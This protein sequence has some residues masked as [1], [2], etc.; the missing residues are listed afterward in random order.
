MTSKKY[1]VEHC[2]RHFVVISSH[3][4]SSHEF[5]TEVAR[6]CD[7]EFTWIS[8]MDACKSFKH[9]QFPY[10]FSTLILEI[11]LDTWFY[12]D[13]ILI[14]FSKKNRGNPNPEIIIFSDAGEAILRCATLYAKAIGVKILGAIS[15]PL[16]LNDAISIIR[17]PSAV[18]FKAS[19]RSPSPPLKRSYRRSNNS[20][21]KMLEK[22][23]VPFAYQ[24]KVNLHSNRNLSG[25]EQLIDTHSFDTED[26]LLELQ[27]EEVRH[28]G[29]LSELAWQGVEQALKDSLQWQNSS[30][31]FPVSINWPLEL[32]SDPS[33]VRRLIQLVRASGL[34]PMCLCL[35]LSEHDAHME[36]TASL[37]N[38][39]SLKLYGFKISLDD[40][41]R[42]HSN[43]YAL[44][45]LPIT[46]VKLDRALVSQISTWPRARAIV[47]GIIQLSQPLDVRV[48][49]EGVE[50]AHEALWLQS[51]GCNEIQGFLIAP[52]MGISQ[53]RQWLDRNLVFPPRH[54]TPTM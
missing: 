41:G 12:I 49:A 44:S 43:L 15:S 46:E 47:E 4:A 18:D 13:E 29:G 38:L 34:P 35:E 36:H 53:F 2:I 30:I 5:K 7:Y 6:S 10:P 14:N 26:A 16:L 19:P 27:L 40:F 1:R 20:L 17:S 45:V 28:A 42:N 33:Q 9:A 3:L 51:V 52:K 39:I 48:V 22:G 23:K 37:R 54:S 11:N 50:H 25:C 31:P 32:L 8:A 21:L 24:P